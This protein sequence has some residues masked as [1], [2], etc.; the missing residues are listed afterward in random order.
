MAATKVG[1][2]DVSV[3]LGRDGPAFFCNVHKCPFE[4]EIVLDVDGR[5]HEACELCI[6][7]DSELIEDAKEAD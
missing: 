3:F 7:D 6:A 2:R 5:L 1:Y 4:P